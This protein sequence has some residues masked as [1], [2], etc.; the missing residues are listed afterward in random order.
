MNRTIRRFSVVAVLLVTAF[1]LASGSSKRASVAQPDAGPL[2]PQ[3]CVGGSV[4]SGYY[5]MLVSG[6]GKYLAGTVY[7]DGNCNVSGSNITGGSAGQYTTTSVTG[8]YGQNSDGTVNLTLNFAGQTTAQ[9]Y[10]VGVS[11]SGIKA[12]GLESDGT[13][14]AVID[15]QSQLTTLPSGYNTASLSGTY[16]A[17]CGNGSAA[18]LNYVTF[19]GK[20]NLTGIDPYDLGGSQGNSPYSGT[21]SVNSDGTFSGNLVGSYSSY[22]FNGVIDNGVSEIEYIYN[23]SG[24]GAVLSCVGKQAVTTPANLQGYYGILVSGSAQTGGGGK[25]LSGS[26]YFN[27]AG[28]LTATNLNGGINATYGNTSATG[29]Y[30]LNSDNTISIT[31]NLAGQS[32]PQ[33]YIVGVSQTGNEAVGI[34]TDGT[35]VATIDIQNQLQ[36]P[37]KPYSAASLNG[38]YSASCGGSE[39]DLNYVIFDGQ[40]NLTGVDA[41]DDGAYGNSPYTGT[42]TVNS[43]GTFSGGFAGTYNIFVMTGVIDNGNAEIEYT[44]NQSGV[45]GVVGCIGEST[46]GPVGSN[47]VAAIPALSP[48]PGAYGSSQTVTLSDTTQNAVIYYTTNG[49]APTTSSPVYGGPIQVTATTTVQAIAAASGYDNS[50]IAAGTY[51]LEAGLPAAATPTFN[52]APGS[53]SSAQSVILLDTTP[54]AVI[55]YTTNGNTPNTNSGI[56]GN[57]IPVSATTTIQAIAVASGYGNSSVASGTYT[58]TGSG[59][60][61][62]NLSSYYNVYGIA[63]SGTPTKNGGFDGQSGDTYNSSTLGT[64]ASYQGVTFNFGPAN[65]LDGIS[66]VTVALPPGSYNQLYLLGAGSYG[67]QTNQSF[68]VT[69]T[70]GTTSTFTQALS[71]WWSSGGYPGETIVVSPANIILSNG[72]VSN[73]PVHLYGYTFNLVLGKTA[74]SVKLPSNRD[75]AILAMGLGTT[76]LPTA[77]TPTLSPAPGSYNSAVALTLSDSTTG[78]VIY[79][80]TNGNPPTT[81]S[82]VY[83]TPITVSATTTIAA[84]AAATG[85]GNSSVVSGTYTI[86]GSGSTAVN[87]SSYYN[88]YGIATQGNSPQHGG[89]DNDGYAYNSSLLGS[90]LSYQSLG[91]PM[92]P[93][94]ALDAVSSQTV[95]VTP[96]SYAQL[97]L[98]GAAVNGA[99]TSQ[100]VVVTYTDGSSSTFTQNFSDWAVPKNYT[101]ETTVIQTANRIGSS[102]QTQNGTFYVYGYAFNLTAGKN[103]ATVKLPS[104]R[105]VVFLGMGLAGAALPTAATP[106]FSPAPGTYNSIESVTLSD[107][108]NGDV[109]HYTTDGTTP[110]ASSAVYGG[111]IT[112]S[113]TTTIEAIA[114]ASGYNNS[115]VATGVYTINGTPIVSYIQVNGG[116]WQQTAS[117][118]VA[119]GSTVNLGPQP[120]NG[121]SWSWTGPNGYTSTARQ[122]NSIPLTVGSNV[123]V[124]TYTNSGGV[125][126]TQAFTITVTATWTQISSTSINSIAC[127]SDGTLVV[128]TSS[129]QSVYE[130]V[131][132]KW[133]QLPGQMRRVA[134]VNQSNVWG[135][136]TDANVYRLSGGNWIKAGVNANYIAAGSDGTILVTSAKDNSI[137]KYVSDNN[138][139]NIPG[140][141]TVISVVR[142]NDYFVVGGGNNVYQYNGSSWTTVGS[143][144]VYVRAAS[145]GTVLATNSA[146]QILQYVSPNNWVQV[147]GTMLIAAPVKLNSYFGMGTDNT[148][149]SYGSH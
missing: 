70:D 92:G 59:S 83:S 14:E 57:P 114:V 109:I 147:P 19:D 135:V 125:Q 129:N 118:S 25:Y 94:N 6:A 95:S 1:S 47:P 28:V 122:I 133:T 107:T 80:T 76:S 85:Y 44:Y 115:A 110:T 88:V 139:T 104:N 84:I 144:E 74:A 16:S 64:S 10:L 5:G 131:S 130:Y 43:D 61:S 113:A 49:L 53:Y 35:A 30:S 128:A 52:P 46:Y 117:V 17:F 54:N 126:S 55:Y 9:T 90:S 123:Y 36:L 97:F 31:L 62:L 67:A 32:T 140:N 79:Y 98:L 13:F 38:I 86:S 4:L 7:F 93:A 50:A 143:N 40:G 106:T 68:V 91:F 111:A 103:V 20:G 33:S 12:R 71:D 22:S 136:G 141:A 102:G 18:D 137:W 65:A 27:G 75:V 60:T 24:S 66:G 148:V 81:S 132:G 146:G 51:F 82:P 127:A 41:Y 63:T 73:Q 77:A 56:Y 8:A 124:A 112:V 119:A 58:I 34:E 105:N 100:P 101:G 142:N 149:Y 11:E 87:L 120:L 37:S 96:G 72:S 138:W 89:F 23:L 145:D 48:A 121:G 21:Y 26:V 45:G 134:I 42:Y 69:Y 39:V 29:T 2:A 15:L 108:T 3:A 99:Q 116:S 78:A